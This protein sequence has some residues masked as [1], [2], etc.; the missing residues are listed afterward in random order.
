MTDTA[1]LIVE[2]AV[3]F[4]G[5][6]FGVEILQRRLG[7]ERLRSGMGGRPIVAA[8]K[9]I[10]LG[11]VTPFCTYSAIPLLVGMRRAGV[12]PAG[13]VAFITA[14][15]VLDPI[16]FGA[17]WLIVGPQVAVLYVA[18]TF[19]AAITI[20]L[21]AQRVGVERHLTAVAAPTAARRPST[22]GAAERSTCDGTQD[23]TEP[24]R[25][26][27]VESRAALEASVGLLKSF[28]PLLLVGVAVGVAIEALVSPDTAARL[29]TGSAGAAIPVAAAMGTP[30]Y[31]STELFVPIANSLHTAGVG[32]GAIV[33]LTI[34]GAG[35]NLPEF[36]VLSRMARPAVV[37]V[38]FGYV[39]TV[40]MMGGLLAHL[41]SG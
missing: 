20:A 35:A 30:L 10:A 17:L 7:P 25:G 5:V 2:L 19:V 33:A 1:V 6:S 11:F 21:V 4:L 13:Y 24:W 37:T 12:P 34:A 22:V 16:L 18:V 40:A 26:S 38:F 29:T 27:A 3:L 41:I 9:G 8:L 28:G 32:V 15:P 31:F 36:I 23:E 14:A 39:F